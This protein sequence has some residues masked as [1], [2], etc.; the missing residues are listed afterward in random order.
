MLKFWLATALLIL[1]AL[2]CP[3]QGEDI[4]QPAGMETPEET[5]PEQPEGLPVNW[6]DSS[7]AYATDQAQALTEWMDGFFGDPNYDLEK[8]ESLVRI[9]WIP[10]WDEEDDFQSKLRVR[11]KLQLPRI[12]RRLNL[13]FS[14]D[15][16]DNLTEEELKSEDN[17]GL[18]FQ[19]GELNRSRLDLTLGISTSALR[20]GI[21]F[22]NQGPIKEDYR[23]R[24]TQRVQYEGG[25][26]FYTTGQLNLDR[27]LP[28]QKLLR[29]SNRVV[30]GEETKGAEWRTRVS[31]R[32]RFDIVDR[33]HPLVVSYFGSI[34][35]VT[36]PS[37]TRNRRIGVQL[38]SQVYRRY[39]F[40]DL[41]PSYNFR[42]SQD[43]D[44][45]SGVWNI[46]VRFEILLERDLRRLSA[47]NGD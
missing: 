45:R 7:H 44:E 10:S 19:V 36:D 6:V 18:L 27:I 25:E 24:F 26:G 23:Y 1:P 13:V 47:D 5:A 8:A 3:A 20:P 41:E 35:G 15:D 33:K 9:Q 31:L 30:Y 4:E 11:G 42:K 2:V 22:R 21:R 39:F 40:V 16:G 29:W 28:E 14:D 43:D 46:I 38:R 17:V 34:N 37:L 32:Q 12:S